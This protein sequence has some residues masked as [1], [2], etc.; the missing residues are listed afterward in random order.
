[1][2]RLIVTRTCPRGWFTPVAVMARLSVG[3]VT[4]NL[5]PGGRARREASFS[6]RTQPEDVRADHGRLGPE[7]R[8]F[9]RRPAK[10]DVGLTSPQ[11]RTSFAN[12]PACGGDGFSASLW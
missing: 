3:V 10:M 5:L 8:L 9:I 6:R 11:C 7:L 4:A 1:M 2:T 12:R